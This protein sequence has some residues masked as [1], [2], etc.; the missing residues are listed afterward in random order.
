MK[1]SI[2]PIVIDDATLKQIFSLA[3]EAP[4]MELQIDLRT[5]SLMLPDGRLVDFPID[6][7][8]KTCLLE[9][10][11]Q[12]GYL[13]KHETQIAAYEASVIA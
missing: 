7:F 4:D 9:G 6:P 12:L 5:Q 2:L 8:N 13:M 1:N 10:I 3:E 11:D